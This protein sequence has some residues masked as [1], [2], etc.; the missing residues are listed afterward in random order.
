MK[1]TEIYWESYRGKH[2]NPEHYWKWEENIIIYTIFIII[3]LNLEVPVL[4][5]SI[6]ESYNSRV[7]HSKCPIVYLF[8]Q[9]RVIYIESEEI[10]E[11]V[12]ICYISTH[13]SILVE[14]C[15]APHIVLIR[16]IKRGSLTQSE[17]IKSTGRLSAIITE[18]P[19]PIEGYKHRIHIRTYIL[20]PIDCGVLLVRY[21]YH[22]GITLIIFSSM[23]WSV[24]IYPLRVYRGITTYIEG[25]LTTHLFITYKMIGKTRLF[26]KRSFFYRLY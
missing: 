16:G 15:E 7:L 14:V 9:I 13:L 26:I 22:I 20:S 25:Y 24:Y 8:T 17:H 3:V 23:L 1:I 11:I 12:I 10:N 18:I 19:Y 21:C 5:I 6:W 2:D 4:I